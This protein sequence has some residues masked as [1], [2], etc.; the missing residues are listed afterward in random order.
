MP[1]SDGISAALSAAGGERQ[2][3]NSPDSTLGRPRAS[4]GQ[5][6]LHPPTPHPHPQPPQ[7]RF[8]G[9]RHCPRWSGELGTRG[10]GLNELFGRH[11]LLRCASGFARQKLDTVSNWWVLTAVE[12]CPHSCVD[13]VFSVMSVARQNISTCAF[14]NRWRLLTQ[15]LGAGPGGAIGEIVSTSAGVAGVGRRRPLWVLF[16][17]LNPFSATGP[18]GISQHFRF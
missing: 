18:R 13:F 1:A 17:F 11:S 3:D 5:I 16:P 14:R 9:G 10:P 8:E 15:L 4:F 6:A 2:Q 7:G 12:F